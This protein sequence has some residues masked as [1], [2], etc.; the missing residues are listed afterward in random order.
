MTTSS[1][2]HFIDQTSGKKVE[3]WGRSLEYPNDK[4][5]NQTKF[6]EKPWKL[7]LLCKKQ[8]QTSSTISLFL[9]VN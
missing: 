6:E 1:V 8:S 3:D 5:R 7:G 9:Q 2:E 4:G